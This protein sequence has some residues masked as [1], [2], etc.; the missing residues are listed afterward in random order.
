MALLSI[1]GALSII[2]SAVYRKTVCNP[3]VHPIFVLSIVDTV[4]SILWISGGL[5]WLKG[6]LS[7]YHDLRVG[8]YAINCMTVIFQCVAM[9]V[10]LIYALLAYSSIKQRDFS[11]VYM[12]RERA[13][14]VKVWSPLCSFAAYFIAW[15]L[16]IPL[17]MIPFGVIAQ[18][19]NIVEK[20]NNCSCWCL[21]YYGNLLPR[22]KTGYGN[23]QEGDMYLHHLHD[24]VT[25]YSAVLVANFT[26]VF[27]CMVVIYLKAFCRIRRMILTKKNNENAPLNGATQAMILA[28]HKDAKKRVL[29]FFF[30]YF[31]SGAMSE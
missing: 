6:G 21:P 7:H 8:C 17:V 16:P 12:L 31:I 5:V 30:A 23:G 14:S 9:N 28:A 11:G 29:I 25:A 20:A 19:Y 15:T 26:T 24:Y 2:G 27:C 10:T 1:V 3:K 4:L 13:A 22:G 18:R